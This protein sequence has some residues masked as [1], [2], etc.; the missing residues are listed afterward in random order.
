MREHLLFG[1]RILIYK[2]EVTTFYTFWVLDCMKYIKF[3]PSLIH[4]L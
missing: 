3:T 2:R 1:S 4:F